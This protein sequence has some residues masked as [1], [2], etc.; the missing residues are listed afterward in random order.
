[1]KKNSPLYDDEI[2]LIALFKIIWGGKIKI[3]LI[4]LISF[5]VGFGYNS[6][7]STIYKNSLSINPYKAS[8]FLKLDNIQTLLNSNQSKESNQLYLARFINELA[9]YEE[10][11]ASIKNTKK[12]R[13]YLSKFNNTD[14][15]I[16]L[17]QYAN[18]LE[19][20]APK[21]NEEN[22]I[23]H[24]QWHD[25]EEAKKILQNTLNLTSNNL[26][27]DIN[28]ELLNTLEFQKKLI[29]KNDKDRLY[30]LKEQSSIAKELNIADN[31]IDNAYLSQPS[32]SPSINTTDVAYYLRGYN[33]IDKEIEIIQNRVYQNLEFIEQ[34]INAIKD[35]EINFVDYN[36]YLMKNKSLKNAKLILMISILLGLTIGVFFVLISNAFQSKKTN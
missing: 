19:I 23:I 6:Q 15:E 31:Q 1:M 3:L 4:T 34:E 28:N 10:F 17:F 8:E 30:Y 24:F 35:L 14:Q 36:V 26:K 2:D 25:P 33:A 29:L 12:V 11:L 27:T 22:Y 18:L 16:K 32:V 9:D 7:I 21:K 13:E 5:L 20:F